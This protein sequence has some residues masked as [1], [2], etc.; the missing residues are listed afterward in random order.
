[1]MDSPEQEWE[2]LAEIERLHNEGGGAIQHE[3][4]NNDAD[5]DGA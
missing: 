5:D 2:L 4:G 3:L 1:M